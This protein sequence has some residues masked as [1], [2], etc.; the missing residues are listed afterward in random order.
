MPVWISSCVSTQ[1][2]NRRRRSTS[3]P[4]STITVTPPPG[5]LRPIADAAAMRDRDEAEQRLPGREALPVVGLRLGGA[6]D[7][8]EQVGARALADA[9]EDGH[10]QH[11]VGPGL[12]GGLAR[13]QRSGRGNGELAIGQS[14]QRRVARGDHRCTAEPPG[15]AHLGQAGREHQARAR[16]HA[17][18]DG[19]RAIVAAAARAASCPGWRARRCRAAR[20]ATSNRRRGRRPRDRSGS[21][22]PPRRR[23]ARP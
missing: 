3:V 11:G 5:T 20:R 8:V 1:S 21:A 2:S 10:A 12:V 9:V 14:S 6:L 13:P 22:P 19:R 17:D 7:P 18:V 16:R 15:L 4:T 23:A